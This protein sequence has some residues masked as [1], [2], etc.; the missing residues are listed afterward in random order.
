MTMILDGTNG[1]FLPTWTTATRPASPANGEIGYNSTTGQLDQYVSGAWSSVPTGSGTVNSGT[2]YQLAYYAASGTAVS[3]LGSLGTSGQ[4]LTSGGAGVAPSWA[5]PSA[6]A[7]TPTALGT[8][9]ASTLTTSGNA[10]TAVGYQA[11]RVDTGSSNTALGA[12]ALYTNTT[13]ARNVAVGYGTLYTNNGNENVGIGVAALQLNTSGYYNVAVGYQA[14]Q[15]NITTSYNTAV[16]YQAL[17]LATGAN[18]T[19]V[20]VGA[21]SGIT[22]SYNS[23]F[24]KFAGQNIT[25]GDENICIGY[26]A[27]NEAEVFNLTTQS[28]RIVMGEKGITN[29]YIKVAWTVT[30]DARDKTNINPIPHGLDFVKQLN[31]VSYNFKK[32]RE[33]DT[34]HGNKRYGFLAQDILA[35]EGQDNVII[36]NE[37]NEHLKYQ[38][39]ALVPVLVKA[40]QELNA[41]FDAYVAS[42]P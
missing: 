12:T 36:D 11:C 8:V 34:P 4:V 2:A 17:Y 37:Q 15:S 3:T 19:A 41:K 42:H 24:G 7:A 29:A 38:G 5:A 18:N 30:S 10:T 25:T 27:G 6:T 31:P 9:Y 26:Y 40:L 32:S 39:E 28:L 33:D 1:A 35:L 20:G 23:C 14:L 16:G 22:G 21:G 13:G